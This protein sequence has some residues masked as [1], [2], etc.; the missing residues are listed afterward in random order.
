MAHVLPSDIEQRER[1]RE[2][3]AV[4]ESLMQGGEEGATREIEKMSL[5]AEEQLKLRA[6]ET[7]SKSAGH[8]ADVLRAQRKLVTSKD[9]GD[10]FMRIA[11]RMEEAKRAAPATPDISRLQQ[12]ME[13]LRPLLRLMVRSDDFRTTLMSALRIA[14]HVLEQNMEGSMEKVMEKGERYG[15]AAATQE[16]KEAIGKTV[17]NIQKKVEE[18]R[19]IISDSDWEKLSSELDSL[20]CKFQSHWE[21]RS[22]V[23][24][25]FCLASMVRSQASMATRSPAVESVKQEAKDLVAQFSGEEALD[26]LIDSVSKFS[27]SLESH[28]EAQ[29]WWTEFKEHMLRITQNYRG[30]Q[31]LNKMR[32][33]FHR[34]FKVFEQHREELEM[35]IDR[36]NMVISNISNDEFVL[37]LR[38]SL[39]ALSDDLYWQDQEG[40]RYFDADAGGVLASSVSDVIRTQFKYLALPQL[41]RTEED[42]A[43]SLDNLVIS[44]TLPDKIDFHLESFASFDTTALNMPGK[45]SLQSEIYL[46]ATIKGI[47]A[48]APDLRFT[49][50]GTTI[51]E[52]GI[53]TITIPSPGANLSIDFVMRPHTGSAISSVNAPTTF[54]TTSGMESGGFSANLGGG[55]MRYEFVKIKSHFEI[56]DMQIDYDNKTLSHQFLVPLLTSVFKTRIIDRFES[57]IEESLDSGLAALGHRVVQILNDAPNPLSISS[58]GS[59]MTAV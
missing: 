31:D 39:S 55:M 9:L 32:D 50:K 49:Y 57:G 29:K 41:V 34:G 27:S 4:M 22:G 16:A 7:G 40:N 2:R 53:M 12:E 1:A 58:F 21:F 36:M 24:Q 23:N 26:N 43:Y 5:E 6:H 10:R 33:M 28:A 45:S 54:S 38:E 48:V 51:S 18:H 52:S 44:A 15:T 35:I 17:D 37:K 20:F 19:D 8:A 14:K 25:L 30:E 56:P 59:M 46:T 13:S 42:M 11:N 3:T 47:T